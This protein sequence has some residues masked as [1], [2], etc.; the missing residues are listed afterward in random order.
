MFFSTKAGPIRIQIVNSIST[1]SKKI[2]T[3]SNE[4]GMSYYHVKY[5]V[6]LLEDNGFIIKIN[7]KYVI[8]KKF[9]ENYE[10]LTSIT[11]QKMDEKICHL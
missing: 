2:R 7:S 4:T 6:K 1:E 9:K 11:N 10:I 3:I 8:S 5:N